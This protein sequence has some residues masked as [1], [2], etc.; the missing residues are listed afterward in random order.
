MKQLIMALAITAFAYCSADAQVCKAKTTTR[1]SSTMRVTRQ[2]TTVQ[3]CRM[4]PYEVCSINP[5]RRSVSCFKTTDPDAIQP[6]NDKT[7]EYGAT[8]RMPGQVEKPKMKTIVIKGNT[9]GDYCKRDEADHATVCYRNG[10]SLVRD[11][12]GFYSYR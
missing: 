7:T 8:G 12:N 2:K 11:E 4:L 10:G 5:D 6:L 1:H 9:K 3:S